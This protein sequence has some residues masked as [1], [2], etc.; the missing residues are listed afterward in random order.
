MVLNPHR[1][2]LEKTIVK[3]PVMQQK[4]QSKS[5][6]DMLEAQTKDDKE[7]QQVKKQRKNVHRGG[8]RVAE[9]IATISANLASLCAKR[10][11]I[12]KKSPSTA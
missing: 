7:D 12:P 2:E 1:K 11:G 9:S 8:L 5:A 6:K 10:K 3:T 4:H